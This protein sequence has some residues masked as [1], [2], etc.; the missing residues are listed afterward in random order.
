[1]LQVMFAQHGLQRIRSV[2]FRVGD[3][4]AGVPEILFF[5]ERF[6]SSEIL[7]RQQGRYRLAVAMDD[8][9]LP[10]MFGAPKQV[11]EL[12]FCL[13]HSDVAHSKI[14]AILAI[15]GQRRLDIEIG[16]PRNEQ[17]K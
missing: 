10:A 4:R 13:C 12:V 1:M 14:M 9:T 3:G 15:I 2:L 7:H 16:Q 5:F 17:R 11:R 6:D 8:Q